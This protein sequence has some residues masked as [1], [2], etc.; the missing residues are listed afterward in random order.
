MMMDEIA[1]AVADRTGLSMDQSKQAVQAVMDFMMS[2]MPEGM[3][4]QMQA[5]MTGSDVSG[6]MGDMNKMMGDMGDMG[7]TM[8]DVGKMLGGMGGSKPGS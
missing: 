7:K 6:A 8:G 5:M 3:G 2:R 4:K 1:K